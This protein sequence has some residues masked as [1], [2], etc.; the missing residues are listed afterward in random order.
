MNDSAARIA[1]ESAL[2]ALS[3]SAGATADSLERAA[4]VAAS[5]AAIAQFNAEMGLG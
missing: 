5:R 3:A 4:R 1:Y 2:L